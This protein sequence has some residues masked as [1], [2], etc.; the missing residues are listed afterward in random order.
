MDVLNKKFTNQHYKLQIKNQEK[1]QNKSKNVE[2]ENY[3]I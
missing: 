2:N 1:L 3:K